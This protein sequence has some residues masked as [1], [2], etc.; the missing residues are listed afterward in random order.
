MIVA[1][2]VQ[3]SII[4][5]AWHFHDHKQLDW[6]YQLAIAIASAFII[7][8]AQLWQ[9]LGYTFVAASVIIAT[10]DPIQQSLAPYQRLDG[11]LVVTTAAIGASG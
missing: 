6:Y 3:D 5:D 10:I 2:E 1:L 11:N 4:S 9:L 8:S 7:V